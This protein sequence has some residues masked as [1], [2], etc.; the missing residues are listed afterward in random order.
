MFERRCGLCN[1]IKWLEMEM[2]WWYPP[3]EFLLAVNQCVSCVRTQSPFASAALRDHFSY[4][5][6]EYNAAYIN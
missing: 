5:A 2:A 1:R 6:P 3:G 4:P